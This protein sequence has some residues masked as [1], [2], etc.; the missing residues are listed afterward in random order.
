MRKPIRL[1]LLVTLLAAAASPLRAQSEGRRILPAVAG[2]VA[3]VAGGGYVALSVVVAQAR[4]GNYLHDFQELFGWR[5][6]P[7]IAGGALGAGLGFYSPH[8]LEQ[9]IIWGFG[10]M[11]IGGAVGFGIGQLVWR[12]PEG[13]WAGAAIG[14]GAGLVVGY[15]TGALTAR[16]GDEL[17]SSEAAVVPVTIRLP[18]Q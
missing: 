10:G 12:P 8:R 7:V 2:G 5:S 13:K 14:A 4:A 3:G 6:V 16:S 11:A 15:L 9:A 18:L 17:G 1:V